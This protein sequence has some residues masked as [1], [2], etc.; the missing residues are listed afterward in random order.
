MT[1]K[2]ES[3]KKTISI[4]MINALSVSG[5]VCSVVD[6]FIYPF[7]GAACLQT[8]GHG[9]SWRLESIRAVICDIVFQ[10][11]FNVQF[12]VCVN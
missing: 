10:C 5:V 8:H 11:I 1:E 3:N 7:S 2:N 9:V 12:D 6:S 4:I